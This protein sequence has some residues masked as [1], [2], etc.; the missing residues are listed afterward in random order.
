MN[1]A[2]AEK[3]KATK[4]ENLISEAYN[5]LKKG[6][7]ESNASNQNTYRARRVAPNVQPGVQRC[8]AGRGGR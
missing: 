6:Y 2:N 7:D 4:A 5:Q 1:Q 8:V 3:D